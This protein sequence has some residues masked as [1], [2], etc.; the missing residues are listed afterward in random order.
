MREGI[1]PQ[2]LKDLELVDAYHHVLIPVHIPELEGYY[3]QSFE[4][5]QLCLRSLLGTIHEKTI[6]T[7]I[8][9][10]SCAKVTQYMRELK[11]AGQIYKLIDYSKNQGKV[12]PIIAAMQ[13][14]REELITVSDCDVLFT[15]GWQQA[16]EKVFRA[17]PR[18]GFVSPLPQP[19][20]AYYHTQWS[21]Y[22]GLSRNCIKR[23]PLPDADTL[24]TLRACSDFL[25]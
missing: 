22:Y 20:L 13:G 25:F 8:N 7:I 1:N 6:V 5:L 17:F 2:K 23:I 21:W 9:N 3:L 11:D 14:C 15:A 4:V 12:D 19:S 10:G 16:V 18:A 24:L